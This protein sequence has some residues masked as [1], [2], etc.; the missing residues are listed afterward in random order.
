MVVCHRPG[1][2]RL[3][4]KS[5][6]AIET[7]ANSARLRSFIS[8]LRWFSEEYTSELFDTART[9]SRLDS[10]R[11]GQRGGLVAAL[12]HHH[13]GTGRRRSIN[14]ERGT[15]VVPRPL[16]IGDTVEAGIRDIEGGHAAREAVA[17]DAQ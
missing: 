13:E 15:D 16:E 3:P 8:I 17:A 7:T 11:P 5:G 12:H 9:G 1:L 4:A 14:L 10:E 6:R 2:A